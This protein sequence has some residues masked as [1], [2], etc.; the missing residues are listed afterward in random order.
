M[1][2]LIVSETIKA[3]CIQ[4]TSFCLVQTLIFLTNHPNRH[5]FTKGCFLLFKR[6]DATLTYTDTEAIYVFSFWGL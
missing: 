6:K 3:D 4:S 2:K 1:Q 5:L